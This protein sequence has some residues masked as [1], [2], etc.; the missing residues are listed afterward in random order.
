[1]KHLFIPIIES[2]EL[3]QLGFDEPCLGYHCKWN[4]NS[5][6]EFI[7]VKILDEEKLFDVV[8]QEEL[9]YDCYVA[10]LYQQTFEWFREKHNLQHEIFYQDHLIKNGFKITDISTNTELTEFIF[11]ANYFENGGYGYKECELACLRKL[12]GIVKNNK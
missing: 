12:I 6:W 1:M 7:P 10:P 2:I 4:D 11:K 5:D 3:N 9:E 8:K